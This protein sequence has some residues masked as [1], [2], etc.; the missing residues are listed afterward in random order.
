LNDFSKQKI[1]YSETNDANATKVAL[2]TEG[3]FTDKT[4]FIMLGKTDSETKLL[5]KNIS[6]ETFSWYMKFLAPLLGTTGISLTKDCVELFPAYKIPELEHCLTS[7]EKAW[8]SSS[9]KST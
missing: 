7:E 1:C 9:L 8:I 4:C 5:Y 6:S 3:F 2:D